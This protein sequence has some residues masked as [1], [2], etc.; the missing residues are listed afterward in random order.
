MLA[1]PSRLPSVTFSGLAKLILVWGLGVLSVASAT[2]YDP[3]YSGVGT[4]IVKTKS[5]VSGGVTTAAAS[6]VTGSAYICKEQADGKIVVAA[7]E[8]RTL[9]V[10]R[11]N[12]DGSLDT[13]FGS[14]GRF[15]LPSVT[16]WYEGGIG[17]DIGADGSIVLAVMTYFSGPGNVVLVRLTPS[18]TMDTTLA[19]QGMVGKAVSTRAF[20]KQVFVLPDG[21]ILTGGNYPGGIWAARYLANGDGDPTFGINGVSFITQNTQNNHAGQVGQL[22][23]LPDGKMLMLS[24]AILVAGVAR[25]MGCRSNHRCRPH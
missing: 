13:S 17:L 20:L 4:S 8:E 7:H 24:E 25:G 10:F 12:A 18:G 22:I 21:K 23:P 6:S 9:L 5:A 11:L 14:S 15:T 3:T 1:T 19:G 2:S 16:M